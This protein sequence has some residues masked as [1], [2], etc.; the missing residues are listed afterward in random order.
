MIS[1]GFTKQI[2]EESPV[3]NTSGSEEVEVIILCPYCLSSVDENVKL[4][5]TCGEDT[6][7]DALVEMTPEEYL[8]KER[9]T[10]RFCDNSM[11][12]LAS[13]CP[14]CRRWQDR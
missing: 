6:T 13:L 2:N 9:K 12:K 5:P 1:G 14:S 7:R 4:C 3:G 8:N 10:C 11:V